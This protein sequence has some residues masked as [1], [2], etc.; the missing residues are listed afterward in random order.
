M[1]FLYCAML[2][3]SLL[4][5]YQLGGATTAD[6]PNQFEYPVNEKICEVFIVD[7]KNIDFTLL[8]K[9]FVSRPPFSIR[10]PCFHAEL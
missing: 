6:L 5:V 3:V 9:A 10:L 8:G 7:S 2:M 4:M 1:L